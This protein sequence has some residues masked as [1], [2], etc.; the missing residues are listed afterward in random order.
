MASMHINVSITRI[1][2]LSLLNDFA[3]ALKTLQICHSPLV[4]MNIR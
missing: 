4:V 1:C 3:L 2:V